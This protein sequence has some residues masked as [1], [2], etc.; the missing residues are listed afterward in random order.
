MK[1]N[2]RFLLPFVVLICLFGQLKATSPS[3]FTPGNIVVYRIGA[4]T[5]ALASSGDTVFIDEYTPAGILVQSI[6]MPVAVS[7]ANHALVA[8]GTATSE[9]MMT[10]SA[11]G[12]YILLTGYDGIG[13][14]SLP[15][16]SSTTKNRVVGIVDPFGN[17]NTTT[18]LTDAYTGNN[19]RGAVSTNGT[20]I[21]ISGTAS[22]PNGSVR[23]VKKGST[24][25]TEL[26][27]TPTN[28]RTVNVFGGQLY[29]S[30]SSGTTTLATVGTGEPTTAGQTITDLPG[31]PTT[32]KSF[33]GFFF[34]DLS[35]AVPGVDVVYI[36]DDGGGSAESPDPV[37]GSIVKYS[38]V[39]GTWVSNG[40][41]AASAPRGLTATV[42]TDSVVLFAATGGSTST[43]GGAIYRYSDNTG[44]NGTL[45]ATAAVDTIA[46]AK[47][48]TAFR[49]IAFAPVCSAPT[50]SSFTASS[51]SLCADSMGA[52]YAVKADTVIYATGDTDLT[53]YNWWYT[54][55]GAT[56]NTYGDTAKVDFSASAT[57]GNI[58]VSGTNSCG[59]SD[60]LSVAVTV[61]PLPVMPA[62]F[63]SSS[64]SVCSGS[65]GV[66][67]AV[68]N[69]ATVTYNWSYSG[70]GVTINGSSNDVTV[71][72][73]NSATAGNVL[74]SATNGCGTSDSLS[75]AVA[76]TSSV[77]P[78]VSLNASPSDTICA[79]T[80]VTFT[81]NATNGGSPT[82]TWMLN[83]TTLSETS[84][85]YQTTTLNNR[86]TVKV[87]MTTSLTCATV[88]TVW[89]ADTVTVNAL[90]AVTITSPD[91]V[92]ANLTVDLTATSVTD[93]STTG[94]IYTYWLV[95]GGSL[96][97]P[98]AVSSAGTYYI[99]GTDGN[100]CSTTEP[101]TVSFNAL[102]TLSITN[103]DAV[104][105]PSTID[106]TATAVTAGSTSGLTYSYWSDTTATTSLTNA[107]TVADSGKYF[108]EGTDGNG[109]TAVEPVWAII[110]SAPEAPTVSQFDSA[111]VSSYSAGN[112]WYANGSST[113]LSSDNDYVP[114]ATGSYYVVYTAGN[115]CSS[116]SSDFSYTLQVTA[117]SSALDNSLN[118]YP[119]PSSSIVNI[120]VGSTLTNVAVTNLLGTKVY[121]SGSISTSNFIINGLDKGT[122]IVTVQTGTGSQVSKLVIE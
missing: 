39:S 17:I 118:I 122:Y 88:P 50:L 21:W 26:A 11:D 67:Y 36:A 37:A 86:D 92:C 71:D 80:S 79:G 60:T 106:L 57:S 107:G 112:T 85:T 72:F 87:S 2:L 111:L 13:T 4:G 73:S 3:P 108:I 91:A 81:A 59:I 31:L 42:Y 114:T 100:G 30:S 93:G 63:T 8:S 6:Q 61:N 82:Y 69:D 83:G 22:A 70:T 53:T 10:R 32:G 120:S 58:M 1:K 47:A 24:T 75:L 77:T 23:Y 62:S 117:V 7:G 68:A 46:M 89:D 54:G 90:P 15:G 78:T 65:T 104:C 28:I 12:K 66:E 94:L 49:G 35:S 9:G 96:S 52:L 19:I 34:A 109:C 113:V 56:L 102:P 27:T 121:N 55:T 76:I 119:N 97:D 18:A 95:T 38:L 105:S 40:Y 16:T 41:I 43:G 99:E 74:V 33:Y 44:Y 84:N 64:S 25:S 51:T 103:P 110:N 115:G 20:D 116:P 5:A 98:A 101:V 48:N 29:C 14:S 45:D